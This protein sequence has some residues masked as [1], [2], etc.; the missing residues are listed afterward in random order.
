MQSLRRLSLVALVL[1]FAQIVFGAIVRITGSGMGCGDHWPKCNGAWFPP[2]NRFDLIIEITHRYIALGLSLLILALFIAAFMRRRE[3]SV[4]GPGG[5]LRPATIAGFLVVAAALLGAVTVKL[6]LNPFVIAAHLTIAM[7]LLATL[8]VAYARAGGFGVNSDM[9]GASPRT[10]RSARAAVG[11]A[12][13][14]LVFGALTAN[15][16][17]AAASCAGFPWCREYMF[18]GTP[19]TI[20]VTHR[21]LAFLLFGHLLGIALM[22]RKRGDPAVIRR[23]AWAAFSAA[24]IQVLVAAAMIE[25]HFPASFRSLHQ[26]FGT[27]VWLAIVVLAILTKRAVR[28]AS[29]ETAMRQAA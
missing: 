12:L 10:F 22:A 4:G 17:D 11:L 7:S 2:H 27:L 5:I 23:A 16:P 25:M 19:L 28:T 29:G 26:A 13:V 14:T 21:I 15:M 8:A 9:S 6:A 3:S 18:Y 20:Q 24:V 1:A